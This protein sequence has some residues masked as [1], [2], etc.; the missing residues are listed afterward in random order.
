MGWRC[1]GWPVAPARPRDT[2]TGPGWQPASGKR[3]LRE[4]FGGTGGRSSCLWHTVNKKAGNRCLVELFIWSKAPL[5]VEVGAGRTGLS[6]AA[7]PRAAFRDEDFSTAGPAPSK[8]NSG[9]Y[10][11]MTSSVILTTATAERVDGAGFEPGLLIGAGRFP[12]TMGQ[13]RV[14]PNLTEG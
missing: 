12:P 11:F 3:R 7:V 1:R 6:C 9:V 4:P 14:A 2:S 10:L 8:A 5:S 13:L